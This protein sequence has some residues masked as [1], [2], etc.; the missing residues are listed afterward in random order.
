MQKLEGLSC[1]MRWYFLAGKCRAFLYIQ[2]LLP[3]C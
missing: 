2:R 1:F 3:Y